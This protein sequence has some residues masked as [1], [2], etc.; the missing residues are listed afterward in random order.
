MLYSPNWNRIVWPINSTLRWEYYY[1]EKDDK[2]YAMELREITENDIKKRIN[3]VERHKEM[4]ELW[5][6]IVAKD[7]LTIS[8]AK[9]LWLMKSE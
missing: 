2:L 1:S 6:L 7:N 5:R 3:S 4:I 8:G 9:H